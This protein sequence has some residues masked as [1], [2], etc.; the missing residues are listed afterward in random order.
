MAS[1]SH[2]DKKTLFVIKS[3]C[4][5]V[6]GL[7][8]LGG[9]VR[10]MDAGLACPDWPLCFGQL[11]P[12]FHPQ[13]YF[14]FI[15]RVL[16][17]IVALITFYLSYLIFK[18]PAYPKVARH[19]VVLT[20]FILLTQIIMG[21]LTVL[22]LLHFGVVTAHLALGILFF[23]CLLW[24]RFLIVHHFP[25]KNLSA[26]PWISTLLGL[27]SAVI[28]GQILLGG[29]VS[30]NYAGLACPDFPL[31]HGEWI[32]TLFDDV[33]LQVIHRLGAYGTFV[34]IYV[35]YIIIRMNSQKPWMSQA[36][37]K[38][39]RWLVSL[40][41]L[42]I[43]VGMSNVIFKIPPVITVLHLAVAALILATAVNMWLHSLYKSE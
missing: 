1:N 19:I 34:V 36:V 24:L 7:I 12:D 28:F 20:I 23:M 42:Q 27:V 32:P 40:I 39:S 17:G 4:V 8:A 30:S 6:L 22:K 3:L 31:C 9:A 37:A 2:V 10:A 35:T 15:H 18:N 33:G 11:V 14:E 21:G 38:S 13:V 29:M 16:A 26:P 41:L 5:L 43:L 25:S